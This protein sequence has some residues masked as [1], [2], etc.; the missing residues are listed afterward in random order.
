MT[1]KAAINVNLLPKSPVMKSHAHIA[2]LLLRF[3]LGLSFL[4]AVLDRFGYWGAPG[5]LNVAWGNMGNFLDFTQMLLPYL[6]KPVS[7]IFGWAAT[8]AEALFGLLLIVGYRTRLAAWGSALLLLT[9]A[10]SMFLFLGY[11]TPFDYSVF[12]A[13]AGALLLSAMPTYKWSIDEY[14]LTRNPY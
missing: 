12:S 13:A 6:E 14:L 4:S 5:G 11:K 3:A 10:V 2:Q 9:F 8:V 7:D 1:F